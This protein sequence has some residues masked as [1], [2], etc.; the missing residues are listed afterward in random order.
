MIY[1]SFSLS[2]LAISLDDQVPTNLQGAAINPNTIRLTWQPSTT[3]CDILGYKIS[4]YFLDSST[5]TIALEGA[6]IAEVMRGKGV[7]SN[8]TGDRPAVLAGCHCLAHRPEP[9]GFE[10]VPNA[11]DM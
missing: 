9:V 4:Y 5:K 10:A 3:R 6:D 1:F 7:T 8:S 11:V 2:H